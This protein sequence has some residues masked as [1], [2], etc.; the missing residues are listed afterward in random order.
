[1]NDKTVIRPGGRRPINTG[2]ADDK[3]IV[4]PRA[5]NQG[6]PQSPPP[7][8]PRY[9][10]PSTPPPN[11]QRY[12]EPAMQPQQAPQPF[13]QQPP[14]AAPMQPAAAP[15]EQYQAVQPGHRNPLLELVTPLI[16]LVG[17]VRFS[18]QSV[19]LP[20]LYQ[21][22]IQQMDYFKSVNFFLAPD[23]Q[24]L[25]KASYGLCCLI[26]DLVLNT[27]WGAQSD[28][29]NE[30]LLVHYHQESWGGENFFLYL[31]QM[32]AN[33]IQNLPV[34]ELYYVALELGF[35]GK[36]RQ[37]P[38][39][40]RELNSVI[41]NTRL[42][43]LRNKG[44]VPSALSDQWQ[45]VPEK[46]QSLLTILP[47]WV[48]WSIAGSV[49][50]LVYFALTIFLNQQADPLHRMLARLPKTEA[51]EVTPI[52]YSQLGRA[53]LPAVSQPDLVEQEID[54]YTLLQNALDF[55]LRNDMVALEQTEQGTMIRLTDAN[56]FR[57]GSDVL[58]NEYIGVVEKIAI[59]LG[60][61]RL[62]IQVTGHTDN[63]PI[64]TLRFSN[65]WALSTAR[66][67]SVKAILERALPANVRIA[68]KGLADTQPLVDNS[69][70]E[71]RA[72]N[73]RVEILVRK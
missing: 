13:A 2:Q 50:L 73:R 54:F 27:P 7:N 42:M 44:Q 45:G 52:N 19:D 49:V 70:E 46:R 30:S 38:N 40:D 24:Q 59:A 16:T 47:Q 11:I 8:I 14:P 51:L 3:T 62:S 68:S 64:R 43:L 28:W 61:N 22:A 5:P 39:G 55:E 60:N 25:L 71:N 10:L 34:I 4:R 36:Y 41:S 12:A 29:A 6:G 65:N 20:Q 58:A 56:L 72:L 1:M 37:L 32:L 57:S 67:E 17:K 31:E 18:S 21:Y 23:P 26:D 15:A 48:A 69:S 63:V 9:Q 35:E 66:A 53:S 33:P